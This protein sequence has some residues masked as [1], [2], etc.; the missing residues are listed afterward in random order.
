M[1]PGLI[2]TGT[3]DTVYVTDDTEGPAGEDVFTL[4]LQVTVTVW[5]PFCT[6]Y[7]VPVDVD[8]HSIPPRYLNLPNS[9]SRYP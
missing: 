2:T 1:P 6:E 5:P 8:R 3:I 7:F 4:G 9:R